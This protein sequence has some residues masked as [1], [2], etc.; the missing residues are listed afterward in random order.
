M[1]YGKVWTYGLIDPQ[2]QRVFYVGRSQRPHSR[3]AEHCAEATRYQMSKTHPLERLWGIDMSN[4]AL[5]EALQE[6]GWGDMSVRHLSSPKT[7]ESNVK[8][9]KWILDLWERELEPE[10]KILDEWDAP[11]KIDANRLEDAWIAAM[12]AKRQ[13][14]TNVIYS[15]RMNPNWYGPANK[16]YKEGWPKDPDEYIARLKSG[17]VANVVEEGDAAEE[18]E[19]PQ[20]NITQKKRIADRIAR[21]Q[22]AAKRA[23][24]TVK[25]AK[26]KGH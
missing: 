7:R 9:C 21:T 10:F 18:R 15:H 6:D 12:R 19:G 13:P 8:K 25:K 1:A 22:L 4:V 5:E 24:T 11:T 26:R 23:A 20:L 2:T 17:T 16:R 14:L 3:F